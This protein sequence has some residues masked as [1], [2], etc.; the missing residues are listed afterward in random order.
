LFTRSSVVVD[1]SASGYAEVDV[2][3][4]GTVANCALWAQVEPV[5]TP[6]TK[7]VEALQF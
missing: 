4:N 3:Q 2:D 5:N 7:A 6:G 1:T